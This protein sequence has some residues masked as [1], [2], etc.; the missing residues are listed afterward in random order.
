MNKY[1]EIK[2]KYLKSN[3]YCLYIDYEDIGVL[4]H[5]IET[6]N[7]FNK[8]EVARNKELSNSYDK[9][10][11]NIR[12]IIDVLD[13]EQTTNIKD[14]SF[15]INSLNISKVD[16]IAN[17]ISINSSIKQILKSLL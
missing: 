12:K 3:K 9:I 5:I 15:Y 4:I 11:S 10:Y 6:L 7:Q 16:E 2:E 13:E 17:K 1:E 8:Q 14:L